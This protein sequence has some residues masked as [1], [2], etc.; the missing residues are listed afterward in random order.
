VIWAMAGTAATISIANS[1]ANN[2]NFFKVFSFSFCLR[3]G[4]GRSAISCPPSPRPKP[5]YSA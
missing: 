5:D 1:A 2:I 4:F 3:L